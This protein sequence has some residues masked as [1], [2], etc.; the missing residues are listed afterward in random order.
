MQEERVYK[1]IQVVDE[2][3]TFLGVETYT[4]AVKKGCIRRASRIMVFNDSG[5]ILIQKRSQHISKPLL[6]DNSAAG[7]VDEGET[8]LEAAV[9]ELE[10]EL[11][12]SGY[13]LDEVVASH[14]S[15]N[16]FNTLYKVTIPDETK[17][18]FDP[19]EVQE[20]VWMSVDELDILVSHCPD[21]CASLVDVWT[22]FKDKLIQ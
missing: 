5:Q 4:D 19:H 10:E 14:R 12:L 21:E 17:I 9:R 1:K 18:I 13:D 15:G 3:G 22:E 8:F 7:H 6:W 20:V 2:D 11:G 16:F